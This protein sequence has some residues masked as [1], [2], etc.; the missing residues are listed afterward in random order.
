MTAQVT[1][2]TYAPLDPVRLDAAVGAGIL[3]QPQAERL[4]GF[5][6]APVPDGAGE[7]VSH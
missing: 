2:K 5:W 1:A 6:I 4:A 7:S 3:T